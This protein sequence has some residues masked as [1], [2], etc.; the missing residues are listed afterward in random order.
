MN[1][2][3]LL[4]LFKLRLVVYINLH[5]VLIFMELCIFIMELEHGSVSS[6]FIFV[7]MMDGV[8]TLGMDIF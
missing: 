4:L 8:Y 7:I 1:S 5:M 6:A 3:F 2:K